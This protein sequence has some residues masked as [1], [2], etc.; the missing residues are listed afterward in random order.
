MKKLYP[1][2]ALAQ[3][4]SLSVFAQLDITFNGTGRTSAAIGSSSNGQTM[5][6][7]P[8][9]NYIVVAGDYLLGSTFGAGLVRYTKDGVL[10]PNFGFGGRVVLPFNQAYDIV[11]MGIQSNG[12]IIVCFEITLGN[13]QDFP[14][15]V[16]VTNTGQVDYG[17]S[18]TGYIKL[19][20]TTV[21]SLLVQA[22][23]KIVVGCDDWMIARYS[24]DGVADPSFG[25]AGV[26]ELPGAFGYVKAM[27]FESDGS[28]VATGRGTTNVQ[29]IHLSTKGVWDT[30][31]GT[32]GISTLTVNNTDP[33]NIAGITVIPGG[34]ILLTGSYFP[35]VTNP[36]W[37]YLLAE[38][39]GDGTYNLG[40]AGNGKLA[41]P[42]ANY[43]ATGENAIQLYEG[44]I[45]MAGFVTPVGGGPDK[46]GLCR[47]TANGAIDNTFGPGGTEITGWSSSKT[48]V[49]AYS[50]AL[51][52]GKIVVGG[53]LNGAGYMAMRYLNPI[54]L[55]PPPVVD[56]TTS[57]VQNSTL[58]PTDLPLRLYPNPATQTLNVQGLD[59]SATTLLQVVD[60]AG[61]AMLASRSAN[62]TTYTLD[63]SQLPSGT[64]FLT[65]STQTGRRTVSF[66]KTR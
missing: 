29:T 8:A 42:F 4:F 7:Q 58:S 26:F 34:Q 35:A 31:F 33:V 39:N 16:R 59:P 54:I 11:S 19:N 20:V 49:E 40:F 5:L 55:P 56:A 21:H 38:L 32:K 25:T 63:I 65:L 23:D 24:K 27:A 61:H 46:V 48:S 45:V 60:A 28:I 41:I 22:D 14:V 57:T 1:L 64:Y 44:Q 62:Q 36:T 66:V 6:I 37:R 17:F 15:L 3:L 47:V 51:Q 53:N 43:N 9:D 52:A 50:I 18:S 2:L 30:K 12:S 13:E 10:D